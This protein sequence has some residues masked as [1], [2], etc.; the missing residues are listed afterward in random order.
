MKIKI[1]QPVPDRNE[2]SVLYKVGEI[3]DLGSERNKAAVDNNLAVWVDEKG[4]EKVS[5]TSDKKKK[6][7]KAGSEIIEAK[8]SE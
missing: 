5:V 7:T 1:I 3:I 2:P 8:K 6:V 4:T